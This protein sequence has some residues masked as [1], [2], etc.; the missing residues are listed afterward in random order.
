MTRCQ[1]T[2]PS[3]GGFAGNTDLALGELG[4]DGR[5]RL[6]LSRV[7][8]QVHDNAAALDGL[9][10]IKKVGTWNPAILLSLLPRSSVLSHA[11][12]DI[13][14]IVAQVETLT[15]ALRA[16]ANEGQGV[17]LEILLLF[18]RRRRHIDS[19]TRR[20]TNKKLVAWPVCAL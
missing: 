14:T 9:V 1:L 17:V 4:L 2:A 10:N 20:W 15:V 11:D 3:A 7:T 8:E 19:W 18:V 16:V 5:P 6:T 12:N 13:Q